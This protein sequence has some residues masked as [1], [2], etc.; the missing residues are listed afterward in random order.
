MAPPGVT[1]TL[2]NERGETI[3]VDP[4]GSETSADVFR[5]I[6][7]KGNYPA[8]QWSLRFEGSVGG[9]IEIPVTVWLGEQAGDKRD[10]VG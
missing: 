1:A 3:G 6:T 10:L 2:V 8:G 9:D 7:V 5:T 4:A